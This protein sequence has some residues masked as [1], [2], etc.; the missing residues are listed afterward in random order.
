MQQILVNLLSNATKFTDPG[1]HVSV[2]CEA[3]ATAISVRVTDTGCGIPRDRL[4]TIFQPFMQVDGGRR[5]TAEG[6]GLGLSI[7]RDFATGMGGRLLAD[8]QLGRGST[9]TLVLPR[10]VAET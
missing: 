7:S 1:G 2:E 9:F 3:S 8:S 10:V 4:E 6:T 5:R